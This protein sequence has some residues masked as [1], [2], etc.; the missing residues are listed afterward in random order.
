[1]RSAWLSESHSCTRPHHKESRQLVEYLLV[2][3]SVTLKLLLE[4][5]CTLCEL[6]FPPLMRN[7]ARPW[8]DFERQA[9]IDV[10]IV[11]KARRVNLI[12]TA[13]GGL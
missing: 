1:M 7:L 8:Q 3:V 5:C 6:V 9:Q 12:L 4:L 2:H 13:P 11:E 10:H